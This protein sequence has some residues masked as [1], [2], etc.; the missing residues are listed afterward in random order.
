MDED[1]DEKRQAGPFCPRAV[2]LD[3]TL[4]LPGC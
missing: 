4:K 1:E 3:W 2:P